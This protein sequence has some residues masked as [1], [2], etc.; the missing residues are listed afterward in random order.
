MTTEE[1]LEQMHEA[2]AAEIAEYGVYDSNEVLS[3]K[4]YGED[5]T[6]LRLTDKAF[7]VYSDTDPLKIIEKYTNSGYRYD[8]EGCIS[9]SNLT[10]A[11]VNELLEHLWDEE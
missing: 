7:T 8:L 2:S 9:D 5:R 1:L 3:V 10:E 4:T 6:F 11:E